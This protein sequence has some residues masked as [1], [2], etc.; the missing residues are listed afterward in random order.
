MLEIGRQQQIV[1]PRNRE[2]GRAHLRVASGHQQLAGPVVRDRMAE[3]FVE[4]REERIVL[5]AGGRKI[6]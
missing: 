3:K 1:P 2:A 6:L 5:R 4:E